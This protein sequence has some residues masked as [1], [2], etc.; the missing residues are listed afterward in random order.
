MKKVRNI[1]V[2][3]A[4]WCSIFAIYETFMLVNGSGIKEL[5]VIGLAIQVGFGAIAF[6][7]I[8]E[9]VQ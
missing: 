7:N 3:L 2:F 5:H 1:D 8:I 9:N 6:K 4:I